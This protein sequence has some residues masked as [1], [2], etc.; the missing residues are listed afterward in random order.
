ML[1]WLISPPLLLLFALRVWMRTPAV[2]IW[3]KR[4]GVAIGL[5]VLTNW[6]LFLV[7][8]IKAQTPYGEGFQTSH[9]TDGLL[10]LSC[11]ALVTSM[12]AYPARWT[13]ML[14][15][16]LLIT[17]WVV[18]AYAPEHWLKKVDFG[19]VEVDERPVPALVYIGNPTDMEAEAVAL[20]HVPAMSDYFL[21][22]GE[23]RIR[24]ARQ[25]EYINLPGGIWCFRSMR[26]M[27]FIEPLPFLHTNEFRIASPRGEIISVQF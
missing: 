18:I 22:F 21:N 15:N 4:L 6:I 3:K 25:H 16:A 23:A 19:N 11:F 27:E 9:L 26:D 17:L 12:A 7:L 20:V 10:F 8:L 1:G 14:A 13:L 24:L 5:A 2:Q